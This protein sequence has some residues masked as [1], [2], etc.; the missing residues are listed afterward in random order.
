MSP[1]ERVLEEYFRK[2]VRMLGGQTYKVAPTEAGMPDRLVLWPVGRV[3]LVELKKDD[4]KV[5]FIQRVWHEKAARAGVTVH[6]LYGRA[7][8]DSWLRS[9]I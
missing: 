6:V 1:E 7:G 5:S 8:I 4:G 3:L 2:R 9:L